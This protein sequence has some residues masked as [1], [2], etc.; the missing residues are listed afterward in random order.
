MAAE[1]TKKVGVAFSGGGIRSAALCS[2]VLRRLLEKS[3]SF[4]YLSCVSGGG[5]CG[6]SYLE[7]KFRHDGVDDPKWHEKF[8]KNMRKRCGI[9]CDWTNPLRGIFDAVILVL[10]LL[11][12]VVVTP[13]INVTAPCLP[14]AFVVDCLVGNIL[15]QGFICPDAETKSFNT[16]KEIQNNPDLNK[17]AIAVSNLTGSNECVPF[18]NEGMY[19]TYMLFAFLLL[20]TALFYILMSLLDPKGFFYNKVRFLFCAFLISFAFTFTPWLIEEYI[21]VIPRKATIGLLVF[22]ILL[23]L[24]IPFL[25]D[26]IFWAI[27]IYVYSYVIKWRVYKTNMV[28][29]EYHEH[30]FNI[31]LWLSAILL[32]I[33]PYVYAIQRVA[34]QTFN[35]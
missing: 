14:I 15:R 30:L 23:W 12:V 31:A 18:T 1:D 13:V 17:T 21:L 9:I 34:V 26:K 8:F 22:G 3:V 28:G 7:W 16:S 27:L 4:D 33:T 11:F 35:R 2:G 19:F 25:R 29:I 20:A 10:L 24:W 6:A 5:F 32:W